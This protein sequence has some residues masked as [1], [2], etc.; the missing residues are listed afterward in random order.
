MF[1]KKSSAIYCLLLVFGVIFVSDPVFA[2]SRRNNPINQNVRDELLPGR[3]DNL[4]QEQREALRVALEELNQS[5]ENQLEMGNNDAAFEIWYRQI[6]LT[7]F[8]GVREE[9]ETIKNVGAIA[10]QRSR[11]DDVNFL[12]ERL[13]VL[14]AQNTTNSRLNPQLLPYFLDAYETL[15]DVDRSISLRVQLLE[16]ARERGSEEDIK[17]NLESLGTL[18]LSKFDYFSAKPIYEEL[19]TIAQREKDFIAES[20]SLRRLSQINGAMLRP[21][22]AIE[23]RKRLIANHVRNNNLRAVALVEIAVGDD[24]KLLDNPEEAAAFY[25]E[26]FNT[27]WSQGQ[28]AI[29]TDALKRLGNLYEEYEQLDSAL[30]IY[31]ELIKLQQQAYNYFGL[32]ETYERIGII[33][34]QKQNITEARNSFIRALQIAQEINHRQE[35]YR[36]LLSQL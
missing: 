28:F 22:N 26:A 3:T 11:R 20:N 31:D 15:R 27:A 16:V 5:A 7:R 18:Y 21:E 29:A 35:Y 2:Q 24:Y 10:W 6:R 23:Y 25:Q 19:L 12:S 13:S 14:E 34:Q 9:V 4:T 17:S 1:L 8:L 30:V 33:H 36:Q 32:M